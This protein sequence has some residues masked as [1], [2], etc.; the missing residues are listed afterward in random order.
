VKVRITGRCMGPLDLDGL[1]LPQLRQETG[2]EII[3]GTET[4]AET[5]TSADGTGGQSSLPTGC[6]SQLH[7][8]TTKPLTAG[9]GLHAVSAYGSSSGPVLLTAVLQPK[10]YGQPHRR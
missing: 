7:N 4:I 10:K 3:E 9:K 6:T 8:F 1:P 5:V 2:S